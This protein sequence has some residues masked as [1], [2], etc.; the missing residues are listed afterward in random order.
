MADDLTRKQTSLD[1]GLKG[2]DVVTTNNHVD[3]AT[4]QDLYY[5]V[6][7]IN[8]DAVVDLTSVVGDNA[9]NVTVTQGDTIV[10]FFSNVAVGSGTVLAY[11]R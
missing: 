6:K 8:A 1:F 5:A 7:A 2:F 4:N 9:S 11:R 10:G 3:A